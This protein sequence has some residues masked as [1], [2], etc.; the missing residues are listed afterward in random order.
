LNKEQ[1][2]Q[3]SDTTMMSEAGKAGNKKILNQTNKIKNGHFKF[4]KA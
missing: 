2:V 4:C 3:V 1:D